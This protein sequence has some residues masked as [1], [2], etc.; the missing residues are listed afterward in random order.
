MPKAILLQHPSAEVVLKDPRD[1]LVQ[2]L[3]GGL[4]PETCVCGEPTA[5]HFD[6]TGCLFVGCHGVPAR[7]AL[8]AYTD[9]PLG[10][11]VEWG[12]P[13][14]GVSASVANV[15]RAGAGPDVGMFFE[16]LR[17]DERIN[18]TRRIAKL[19]VVAYLTE[20]NK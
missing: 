19:A 20:V 3:V 7:K 15:L 4:R 14:P 12:D 1:P 11:L 9:R 2:A 16:S 6:V 8:A 18:L 13:H 10:D 5:L 17:H